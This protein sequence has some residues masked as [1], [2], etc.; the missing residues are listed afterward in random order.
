VAV[1]ARWAFHP[2]FP[3]RARDHQPLPACL[4]RGRGVGTG[5][6]HVFPPGG[7]NCATGSDAALREMPALPLR[8]ADGF[9]KET[10][11]GPALLD[12]QKLPSQVA[13]IA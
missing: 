9:R 7:G 1:V 5:L 3:L 8:V 2:H 13:R 4:S 6:G 10:A 12:L 11:R